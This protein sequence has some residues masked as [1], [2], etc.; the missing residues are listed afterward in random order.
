MRGGSD[1]R[2][3]KRIISVGKAPQDEVKETVNVRTQVF[4]PDGSGGQ[5][6]TD[7]DWSFDVEVTC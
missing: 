3:G 6:F 1:Q 7:E 5:G 4:G 2:L